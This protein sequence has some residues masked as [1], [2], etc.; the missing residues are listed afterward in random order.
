MRSSSCARSADN[1]DANGDGQHG[2]RHCDGDRHYVDNQHGD[3]RRHGPSR[4]DRDWLIVLDADLPPP[5][6]RSGLSGVEERSVIDRA[7]GVIIGQGH[8]PDSALATLHRN[9]DAAGVEPHIY[10]RRL[11]R[12]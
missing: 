6:T 1:T 8:H 7:I 4:S 3:D 2:H 10:A 12:A 9:A 11:L 5:T